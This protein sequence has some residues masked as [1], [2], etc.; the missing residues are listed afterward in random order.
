MLEFHKFTGNYGMHA[1]IGFDKVWG[2]R[3]RGCFKM[4]HRHTIDSMCLFKTKFSPKIITDVSI[5]IIEYLEF[6]AKWSTDP[7]HENSIL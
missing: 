4:L 5:D 7:L 3:T 6:R 1:H 2:Y